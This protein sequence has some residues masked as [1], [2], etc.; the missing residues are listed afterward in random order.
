MRRD[1][2]RRKAEYI[3]AEM[4]FFD[5]SFTENSHPQHYPKGQII[6]F[7]LRFCVPP[8]RLLR[9]L[10]NR[11][12]SGNQSCAALQSCTLQLSALT[13]CPHN[14]LALNSFMT[15]AVLFM[16]LCEH[17]N[18]AVRRSGV[19]SSQPPFFPPLCLFFL[20]NPSPIFSL[21]VERRAVIYG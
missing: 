11:C 9:S 10:F 18:R 13:Q 4:P 17:I 8:H 16:V 6:F 5:R 1:T 12:Q 15:A 3:W 7:S 14:N 19:W 21:W 2:K 20:L